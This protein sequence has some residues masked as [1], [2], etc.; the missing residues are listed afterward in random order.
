MKH[1]CRSNNV[2][3][4]DA[5]YNQKSAHVTIASRE[6]ATRLATQNSGAANVGRVFESVVTSV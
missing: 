3:I 2:E 6:S 5:L 4:V 1:D